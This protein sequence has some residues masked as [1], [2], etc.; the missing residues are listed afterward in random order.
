[1]PFNTPQI[2]GLTAMTEFSPILD[3]RLDDIEPPK[4][5]P[6]GT[7]LASI[8]GYDPNFVSKNTRTPGVIVEFKIIAPI[9]VDDQQAL[10]DVGDLKKQKPI[11]NTFWLTD[12]SV[13]MLR[14]F[15]VDHVGIDSEKSLSQGLSEM[16][17]RQVGVQIKQDLTQGNQPR[18]FH[19]VAETVKA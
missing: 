2:Q 15:L 3:R 5:F 16:V 12:N 1:M 11:K 4:L 17:N 9:Q 7:Y 13:F 10:I 18:M 8:V 6:P 14:R 19:F